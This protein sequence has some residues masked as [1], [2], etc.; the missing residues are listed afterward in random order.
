M[1]TAKATLEWHGST[2]LRHVTGVVGRAV[3]GPLV[4]VR[5]PD[6]DLPE[7][8]GRA[9]VHEDPV[10]GRGPMQ[11]LAV[12]LAAAA[13]R[14]EVAFVASTDMPFLHEAFVR[15]VL[16]R[17]EPVDAAQ[18]GPDVVLPVVR[19]HRQPMAAGYRTALAPHVDALVEA[20]RLKP[21]Q[22]FEQCRVLRLDEPALLS[23]PQ[24][25]ACDPGLDSVE[26]VN[27]PED[28]AAARSRPPPR[29]AVTVSVLGQAGE[30]R[31]RDVRAANLS[32]AAR[33]LGLTLGGVE[34]AMEARLNGEPVDLDPALPLLAGDEL[35]L[36]GSNAGR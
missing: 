6:Q 25:A 33:A 4:V 5:A 26:N 11:G 18:G 35:L 23:D 20:G 17:F 7:L 2:L 9:E 32:E 34:D 30:A 16:R 12:A 36:E 14:A 21:A 13:G 31:H 19:G 1:G 10:E 24:L 8:P 29:V 28:Y 15:A 27:E 22:L 3:D